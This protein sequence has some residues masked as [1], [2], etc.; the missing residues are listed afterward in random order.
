M[1]KNKIIFLT[2]IGFLLTIGV[3]NPVIA[4]TWGVCNGDDLEYKATKYTDNQFIIDQTLTLTVTFN[5]TSVGDSVNADRRDDGGSA[6][7]VFLNTQSLDDL[8]GINIRASNNLLVR[9]LADEQRIQ[10][11]MTSIQNEVGTVLANFSMS[12]FGNSLLVSAYGGHPGNSWTYDAEINYTSDYVLS[13]MS[14]DHFQTDGVDDAVQ[15]VLWT[16]IYHHSACP[17]APGPSVPGFPAPLII[18]VSVAVVVGVIIVDAIII[19]R[20]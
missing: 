7:S 5:V 3:I 20:R 16:K 12:R 4:A 10:G 1:K 15:T 8:Y 11:L 18:G 2:V 19:K 6:V 14:E 9:Y 17:P 13:R